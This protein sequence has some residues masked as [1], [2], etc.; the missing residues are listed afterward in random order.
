MQRLQTIN[1]HAAPATGGKASSGR[2]RGKPTLNVWESMGLD[3]KLS[4]RAVKMRKETSDMMDSI[5]KDL[6]PHV[7]ATTFPTWLPDKIKPLG[8]N[9]L[10]IKGY[11]SPG[12]PTIEAGASIFEMAKRDGSAATFFLVHNSIGMAVIDGLGDQEQKDRL[13][14]PGI[15]FEKIYCFGLTEPENGSDASGLK[16]TA[17]KVAGGWVLNGQKR[18]I[19]NATIGDVVVW[20][21][22][23]DDGNRI[24][25]FVV[26]KGTAGFHPTKIEGKMA[27]RI[28]QNADITL[29]DCFVP[30]RNKLTHAKDFATGTNAILEASRLMVAWMAAGVSC[31]AYEACLKYCLQRVQF[32]KPIA[33]F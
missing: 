7:E 2:P 27:L 29:R 20:A 10:Q 26:E 24:Q 13:L 14:P 18:W 9:G 15:K 1:M 5:Y 11:G 12:L 28:T 33:Q 32:G 4:E 8:I 21:R 25:A 22:N 6:L 23:V 16:T 17:R 31:G 3:K 19:G 30:D